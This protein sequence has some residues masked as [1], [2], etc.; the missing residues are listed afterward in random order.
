[1]GAKRISAEK[2]EA[3]KNDIRAGVKCK[4]I[5]TKYGI[6][7][8]SVTRIKNEMKLEKVILT[9]KK[10][11]LPETLPDK[12]E[13][14]KMVSDCRDDCR[15][16]LNIGIEK[17]IKIDGHKTGYRY[18]TKSGDS[19]LTV[20]DDKGN[21]FRLEWSTLEKFIDELIDISVEVPKM[22]K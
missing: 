17:V 11:D 20:H 7:H 4:D 9:M 1:M 5:E 14:E 2:R 8:A 15:W 6:G 16:K 13:P 22:L 12:K 3:I 19:E 21:E 10:E 18:M